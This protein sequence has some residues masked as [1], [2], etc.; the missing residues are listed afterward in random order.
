MA[1]S[2]LLRA[3]RPAR[4]YPGTGDHDPGDAR[5]RARAD[6]DPSIRSC[7][8]S[9][10]RRWPFWRSLWSAVFILHRRSSA[11]P[12]LAT[13]GY[14]VSPLLFLVPVLIVIVLRTVSDPVHSLIGLSVV[15]LGIPASGWVLSRP[16]PAVATVGYR[17]AGE[18]TTPP[19]TGGDPAS[20]L[21]STL[22]PLR[23]KWR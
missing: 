7:H 19:S 12:P 6:R 5:R 23:M 21:D 14:P 3:R 17:S 15:A 13:P 1:C 2:S 4:R 10:C 11:E 9:W 22:E 16:R 18:T 8:T 20:G